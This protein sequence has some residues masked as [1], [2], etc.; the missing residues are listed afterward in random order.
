MRIRTKLM[1]LVSGIVLAMGT[2][3]MMISINATIRQAKAELKSTE[4][5]LLAHRKEMLKAILG[6]A[7]TVIETAYREANDLEKLTESIQGQLK[8]VVGLAFGALNEIYEK[9]DIT[10]EEKRKLAIDVI[11]EL[12]FDKTN[13]FWIAGLDLTMIANP[14]YP[15]WIGKDISGLK[16]VNGKPVFPNLLEVGKKDKEAFFN[17]MWMKPDTKKESPRIGYAKVFS[18]WE[19]AVGAAIP[20]ELAEKGLRK[21]SINTIKSLRYGE[22]NKEYFWIHDMDTKMVMHPIDP[23][24]EGTDLRGIKDPDGKALFS[25]MVKVCKDAG[26][27]YVEYI[28]Q[29]PGEKEPVQKISY[30]KLYK[31]LGWIVGTGV[32]VDDIQKSI[33]AK[34]AQLKE[35]VTSSVLMQ[36]GLILVVIAVFIVITLVVARKISLPLINTSLMLK[37]IAEGEGDLTKRLDVISRDEVGSLSKWFNAFIER[38][39]NI[40]VDIGGNAEMVTAASGELLTISEQ[41]SDGADEL[42]GKA[43]SVAVAAEEMSTNMNSVAAASEQA[44]TN[45]GMVTESA[46]QM[47][48]T[49]GE[50]AA[51]CQKARDI[52]SE[53]EAQVDEASTRVGLLG[54]AAK[55]I[56]KVTDVI[57]DIAEQTNLLALNAT[58]EAARAGEAGKGFAVV[59]GEIKSLAAQTAQATKDIKGKIDGIQNSTE[60]TV[61]DV[62]KISGVISDV[63][64]IVTTIAA[65]VE[66]QS[67]IATEVAENIE[68][69]STG[70]DDVNENVAQSSQVSSEIAQDISGVNSV[71]TEML[72][73][74][75]RMKQSARELSD[76][77]STL[78]DMISIFKVSMKESQNDTGLKISEN[79]IPDLMPWEPRF[80]LGIDEIDEQHKKLVLLVNQLHKAM[81]LR[82]G[83]QKSEDI[84]KALADYT[85][86]HFGFE[87]E[88]FEKYNYPEKAKHTEIHKGLVAQVTD[89]KTQFQ[90][91]NAA[92]TIDLMEFL[93][94]WL[95]EH[96]MQTDKKYVP[97][98]KDKL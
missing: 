18:P 43:N 84:L 37:D 78:R 56:S 6:N 77:A 42:S 66:E 26:E 82:K 68:Q 15:G 85:V 30:V 27:G 46:S 79:S 60:D 72:N 38:L 40:I 97:F 57:T 36:L 71:A 70:I 62:K 34:E 16:D 11:S 98:L 47:Q 63:N 7:Y 51:N 59:A 12:R 86:V 65:A 8:N 49:L 81:K 94:N 50:V 41:M 74:S 87:E 76:L 4:D 52:S 64:D 14:R 54:D 53:A 17:Y 88:L 83:R 29:K 67:A 96:I 21:R 58:I 28:W 24:L 80:K 19:W 35:Q 89:F 69:A 2:V 92:L 73:K 5:A 39:H 10:D 90:D 1:I 45:I 33:A 95:K 25:E 44:S 61:E 31:P 9:A 23:D 13:Y 91:G 3:S 20:M 48:S 32:Y 55:D 22:G 93:T 75:A